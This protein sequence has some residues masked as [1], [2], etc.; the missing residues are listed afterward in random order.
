MPSSNL[1]IVFIA[2]ALA[3]DQVNASNAIIPRNRSKTA[4][5]HDEENA[6]SS[7]IADITGFFH[8]FLNAAANGK[9]CKVFKGDPSEVM[10]QPTGKFIRFPFPLGIDKLFWLI[11]RLSLT[12]E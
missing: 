5:T 2:S 3:A 1:G 9:C 6:T 10:P 12:P 7:L 11:G 8:S 4:E